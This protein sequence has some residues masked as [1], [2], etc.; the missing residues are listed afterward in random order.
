MTNSLMSNNHIT[1]HSGYL[2]YRRAIL[3]TGAELH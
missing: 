2:K 3:E 1:A